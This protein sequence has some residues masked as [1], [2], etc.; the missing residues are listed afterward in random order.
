M[1]ETLENY[2]LH[3]DRTELLTQWHPEKN[4]PLTPATISRGSSKKVWWKCEKGHEWQSPPYLRTTKQCGCPYCAGRKAYPGTDLKSLYPDIT[5]QWD[6]QKN[7]DMQPENYLPHSHISVWWICEHGHSWRAM[8]RSRVEGTGCPVCGNKTIFP[9][10]N[11]LAT[12]KP[13]LAKEWHPT[14]NGALTP[15]QVSYGVNRKVWWKCDQGHEWKATVSSRSNGCR[16]PYCSGKL[17]VPG[18]NDLATTV[19][20]IAEQWNY[21]QNGSLLPT[22][23]S[24]YSNKR[25]WWRCELG[26]E[27]QSIISTR[28]SANSSCPY[29]T[30]RKVLPGFNDL[31]TKE[32]LVAK[33]WHPT[34]NGTLEPS[35]VTVG[36][37]KRVWWQCSD[38]HE[39]KAVIYSRTGADK[40]G[41]PVCA[42][43]KPRT[44][45]D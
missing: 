38:G 41:C 14:K 16:C 42:G 40:C 7:G 23:V 3:C 19:P 17:I 15:S 30:G 44:Y 27:W 2:C 9:G 25:V 20:S 32:P 34:R 31:A 29:C 22:Q 43:K 1:R 45:L 4:E 24:A 35:M 8:I 10:L 6:E 26:H 28:T 5:A 37:N 36:S 33:Q 21:D 39:W 13:L 18:E 11:D 12:V